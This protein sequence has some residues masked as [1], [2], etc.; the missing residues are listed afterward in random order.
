[1]TWVVIWT[2]PFDERPQSLDSDASWLM[3]RHNVRGWELP[4]GKIQNGE[5]VENAAIRELYEETGLQGELMGLNS[6]LIE[7][8]HVAWISVP[9][10]ANPISWKS[11]DESIDEVGWCLT[12]PDNIHWGIDELNKIANYWSKFATSLS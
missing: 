4:G 10:S 1:M 11:N 2:T 5:T 12:A 8:G 6:N 7:G 9:M 3:V